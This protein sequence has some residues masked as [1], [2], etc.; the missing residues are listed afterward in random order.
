MEAL[1][2]CLIAGYS[3]VFPGLP[4]SVKGTSST[5]YSTPRATIPSGCTCIVRAPNKLYTPRTT[6]T[7]AVRL[8]WRKTRLAKFNRRISEMLFVR[9]R[10]LPRVFES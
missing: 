7:T 9:G 4:V 1:P 3:R 2:F 8:D 6:T 10:S 5:Y